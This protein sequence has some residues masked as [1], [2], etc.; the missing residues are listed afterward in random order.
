MDIEEY[1]PIIEQLKPLVKDPEFEEL[2]SRFLR[3]EPPQKQFLIKMELKRLAEPCIRVIDTRSRSG[4]ASQEIK[5]GTMTHYL[6][7]PTRAIFDSQLKIF[8]RYTMGVYE[9]VIAKDKALKA[10]SKMQ[11]SSATSD[12]AVDDQQQAISPI[13]NVPLL[14]FGK[15]IKRQSERLILSTKVMAML[16]ADREVEASISDFSIQGLKLRVNANIYIIDNA[17]IHID[18]GFMRA[19]DDH[20]P[21]S[22]QATYRLLGVHKQNNLYKWLRLKRIDNDAQLSERIQR[23]F[24]AQHQRLTVDTDASV[25]SVRA[26]G[27][28]DAYFRQMSAAPVLIGLGEHGLEPQIS[29]RSE[30]N[31]AIF[32]Y[33]RGLDGNV[34]LGDVFTPARL[35]EMAANARKGQATLFFCFNHLSAGKLNYYCASHQQL[36]DHGLAD[37]FL[38]F[39]SQRDSFRVFSATIHTLSIDDAERP[40]SLPDDQPDV[41]HRPIDR[42]TRNKL[43]PLK[44]VIYLFDVTSRSGTACYRN[45]FDASGGNPNDLKRYQL[46]TGKINL[47]EEAFEFRHQRSEVRYLYRTSAEAKIAERVASGTTLNMSGKGLQIQLKKPLPMA[48]GDLMRV[49][50]PQL[51]KLDS[52]IKLTDIPYRVVA[53]NQSQTLISLRINSDTVHPTVVPFMKRLLKNNANK[54]KKAAENLTLPEYISS[55]RNM[56]VPTLPHPA[57]FVSRVEKRVSISHTANSNDDNGL[58]SF[59]Q[60]LFSQ[61]EPKFTDGVNL[62]FLQRGERFNQTMLR[63]LRVLQEGAGICYVECLVSATRNY[64]SQVE[65]VNCLYIMPNTP[66]EQLK[67]FIEGAKDKS[68]IFAIRLTLSRYS[69]PDLMSINRELHYISDYATHKAQ[70]LEKQLSAIMGVGEIIDITDEMLIRAGLHQH[71]SDQQSA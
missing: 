16:P 36:L 8:G 1:R 19:R 27:F 53:M 62:T 7:A 37:L 66:P 50:L 56:M 49:S 6:D 54:L 34:W 63:P 30:A 28:E 32:D 46:Q 60:Q 29:I 55:L 20:K 2:L 23:Y 35:R 57:M 12:D 43:K 11:R 67:A 25:E 9:A 58:V 10:S 39:A 51:Q 18:L 33:W 70:A 13:Y 21:G 3:S 5:A 65:Q 71:N 47:R 61:T 42:I 52:K 64:Q 41:G 40:L 31:K 4:E 26:R 15:N 38:G 17:E 48:M 14:R 68:D 24:D 44:A 22:W 69:D 59:L 45:N